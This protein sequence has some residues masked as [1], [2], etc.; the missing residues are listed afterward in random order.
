MKHWLLCCA[1]TSLL[2]LPGCTEPVVTR[3]AD[4]AI[5]GGEVASPANY[6]TVVAIEHSTGIPF[7][8]GTLIHAS[9]VMT[10]AHCV[11]DFDPDDLQVIF[12]DDDVLDLED[13]PA[14]PVARIHVHPAYDADVLDHDIAV[15]E[16]R[17]P[18]TDR[19]PTPAAR[20]N[21]PLS[22]RFTTL[23]YGLG[24]TLADA[25]VLHRLATQN[26]SCTLANDPRVSDT[27]LMCFDHSHGKGT[28][29]GDS[30]GPTFLDVGTVRTV[31]SITSDA[32]GDYDT[33]TLIPHELPFIDQYVPFATGGG[34]DGS[35]NGNGSGES[36][37]RYPGVSAGGCAASMDGSLVLGIGLCI[38][39]F[40]RRRRC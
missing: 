27:N 15:L 11:V 6:P 25:G 32:S 26:V 39:A 14:S 33:N 1:A 29:T 19:S 12:D 31:A 10:A 17:S 3:T 5:D 4:Q 2:A 35:S 24:D 23:G 36:G 9:W 34:G 30:G 13:G 28:D 7:C 21:V 8:S 16:L 20:T 18:K 38:G 40:M 22:T 37:N